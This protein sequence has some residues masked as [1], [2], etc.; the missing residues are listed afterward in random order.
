MRLIDSTRSRL[1]GFT[2]VE[3]LV[4]MTI[5]ILLVSILLPS[6]REA[7]EAARIAVC[8]SGHHQNSVALLQYAGDNDMQ[9]PP[10]NATSWRG[11]GIDATWTS[12]G[13]VWSLYQQR[14]EG[15]PM[16][17][18]FLVMNGYT[19]AKLLYCPSWEH[20]YHMY[21]TVD[22]QGLDGAGGPYRYGGWPA[23]GNPG[24]TRFRGISYMYRSTFGLDTTNHALSIPG[25]QP[26]NLRTGRSDYA[27][28]ADHWTRRFVDWS[29]F[30]HK[31]GYPTLRL[32]GGVSLVHDY[33]NRYMVDN[34]QYWTHGR[35]GHQEQIWQEFFDT[36]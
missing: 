32:D 17:L 19:D 13:G 35:W 20:P 5:I 12:T 14:G 23:E 18:G 28:V 25:G 34:N 30:G 29:R 26:P 9:L 21:D 8:S 33:E 4:V 10:G 27:I 24:P 1:T 31:A 6:A 2:V 7:R 22:V 3:L 15:Q 36:K 16:G 11:Y